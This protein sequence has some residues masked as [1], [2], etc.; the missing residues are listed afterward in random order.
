MHSA[1]SATGPRGPGELVSSE[2]DYSSFRLEP[3]V[4]DLAD[5]PSV[6]ILIHPFSVSVAPSAG[7]EARLV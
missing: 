3:G 1:V 6:A 2:P 7:R 4:T 5:V